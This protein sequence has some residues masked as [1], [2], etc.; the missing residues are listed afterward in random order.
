MRVYP[1]NINNEENM[2]NNPANGSTF[3]HQPKDSVY[4]ELENN[5]L[6]VPVIEKTF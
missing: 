4:F 2:L 3:A 6:N 5:F 1:D